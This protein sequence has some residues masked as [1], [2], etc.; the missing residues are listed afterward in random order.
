MFRE[1]IQACAKVVGGGFV[2]VGAIGT[3]YLLLQ[4]RSLWD[5]PLVL[6]PLVVCILG[7][8]LL[9]AKPE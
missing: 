5:V 2:V 3:V 9:K 1:L 4:V 7:I 6:F 8:L